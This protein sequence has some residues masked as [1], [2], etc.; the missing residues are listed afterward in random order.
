[1][2]GADAI[3]TVTGTTTAARLDI[4]TNSYHRFLQTIESDGRFRLYNQTTSTEQFN[5]NKR[6]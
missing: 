4:K 5:S 1:M 3:A 6:R 2:A